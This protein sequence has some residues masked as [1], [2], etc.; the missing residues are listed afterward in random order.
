M[1]RFTIARLMLT[2]AFVAADAALLRSTSDLDPG[3]MLL[4]PALQAALLLAF[5]TAGGRRP[6]WVGFLATGSI[7]LLLY[8]GVRGP[9]HRP[10]DR[11]VDDVLRSL[12]GRGFFPPEFLIRGRVSTMGIV[13]AVVAPPLLALP[14]LGGLAARWYARRRAAVQNT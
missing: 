4:V 8:S 7:L 3:A 2:V 5:P 11:W 12:L 13:M 1:P 6:F 9:F 10:F 14:A